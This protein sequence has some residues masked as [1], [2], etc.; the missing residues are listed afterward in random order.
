MATWWKE[1][2]DARARELLAS[3]FGDAA[4]G[5]AARQARWFAGGASF[6]AELRQSFGVLAREAAEGQLDG[7]ATQPADWLALLILLD[8][9]PRNLHR[10][11]PEAF[12]CDARAL[13]LA[14][15]GIE[16]GHDQRL[17]HAAR[18][19]AYL[20]FEHAES[21]A[22][23]QRSLALFITLRDDAPEWLLPA[24]EGW[25]DYAL[26][27]AE[28]IARFGRFPHRNA[29]LGRDTTP[30]EA[31]WLRAHPHGF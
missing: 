4:D 5:A 23:Q 24:A 7:W 31:D 27:H 22:A 16:A 9:L 14:D 17:P 1:A 30:D 20:P 26:R 3:W 21:A 10:D 15:A 13:A 28:P 19:F 2:G 29:V 25:L 8:Q 12:A 11:S 18:L 6:D